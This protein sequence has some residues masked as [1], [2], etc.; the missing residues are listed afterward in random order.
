MKLILAT[1]MACCVASAVDAQPVR[2]YVFTAPA[3][4]AFVDVQS[5]GRADSVQDLRKTLGSDK[6]RIQLVDAPTDA[7]VTIEVLGR[8]WAPLGSTYTARDALGLIHTTEESEAVVDIALTVGDYRVEMRG[9]SGQRVF[10]AWTAAA[11]VLDKQIH[12]WLKDN[13]SELLRRR[14]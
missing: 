2:V 10:G 9:G 8:G 12:K 7:D 11:D 3:E 4:T 1:L 6:K 5:Q 13:T 14:Q